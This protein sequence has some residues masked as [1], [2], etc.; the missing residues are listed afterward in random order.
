MVS[1]IFLLKPSH[2]SIEISDVRLD[3]LLWRRCANEH[4]GLGPRGW[5]LF[6]RWG[7]FYCHVWLPLVIWVNYNDLTVLP[8]EMAVSRGDYPQMTNLYPDESWCQIWD[9]TGICSGHYLNEFLYHIVTSSLWQHGE[10]YP[11]L[12]KESSLGLM[13]RGY[14]LWAIQNLSE[15]NY[16][17]RCP[18]YYSLK[19]CF[20][21]NMAADRG[22][23]SLG[24]QLTDKFGV[25]T[26][27]VCKYT[28]S[29]TS[30]PTQCDIV[31]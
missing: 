10:S 20:L 23:A 8:L 25:H 3:A 28:V 18:S 21:M 5:D 11:N 31:R 27:T 16:C 22:L 29:T 2:R 6:H 24:S 30:R 26:Y 13:N 17:T 1:S 15:N 19:R 12:P 9:A 14:K 7:I 4:P